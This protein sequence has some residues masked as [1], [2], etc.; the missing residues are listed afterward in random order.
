[1]LYDILS[2]AGVDEAL[3]GGILSNLDSLSTA[4]K[5][6]DMVKSLAG[7]ASQP[8]AV[9]ISSPT[10]ITG[11][12]NI[13]PLAVGVAVGG[14]VFLVAVV[15]L[16]IYCIRRRRQQAALSGAGAT[17]F[18]NPC[19]QKGSAQAVPPVGYAHPAQLHQSPAP[20]NGSAPV[21]PFAAH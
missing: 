4:T 3:G 17:V 18:V 6:R 13:I 5:I 15:G 2:A 1:M 7:Q 11:A 9:S 16:T 12:K 14:F 19:T 21:H 8:T 10:L 20:G